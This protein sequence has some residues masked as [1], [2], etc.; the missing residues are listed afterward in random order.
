L[1]PSTLVEHFGTLV[2]ERNSAW[3]KIHFATV[4]RSLY[5]QRYCTALEHWASE[6]EH[7][8]V[9]VLE[10]GDLLLSL[11]ATIL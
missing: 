2:L 10:E 8:V 6:H 5:W 4:L 1:L 7:A 3:C 11:L 9:P